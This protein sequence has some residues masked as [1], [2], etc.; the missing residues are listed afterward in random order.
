MLFTIKTDVKGA[1]AESLNECLP[2]CR[3]ESEEYNGWINRETWALS[4]HLNNTQELYNEMR[5]ITLDITL[6]DYE[7]EDKLRDFVE[8]LFNDV[9]QK[10]E[11]SCYYKDALL[12]VQDVGSLWRVDFKEVVLNNSEI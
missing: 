4:L 2:N 3:V 12:M 1:T 11:E 6:K 9:F 8:D 10:N 5:A 7:K